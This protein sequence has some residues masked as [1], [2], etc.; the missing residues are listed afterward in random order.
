MFFDDGGLLAGTLESLSWAAKFIDEMS[1]VSG[2][3]MKWSKTECHAPGT[4]VANRCRAQLPA[5][6]VVE[7]NLNFKFLK[8]PIGSDVWVKRQ[9][10]TKLAELRNQ[11]ELVS[12]MPFRHEAFTLLKH[13]TSI[14]KVNHL[15]RTL[16]PVQNT[17]FV[18]GFD[19]ILRD[20]LETL[21]GT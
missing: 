14:C 2:L 4:E 9:F 1:S 7:E 3:K 19:K 8:A 11:I 20:A 6:V 10:D 16:P 15:L 17:Q 13:C 12:H 21:L 5:E 18:E